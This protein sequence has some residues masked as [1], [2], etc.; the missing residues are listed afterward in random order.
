MFEKFELKVRSI[1]IKFKYLHV[2]LN[3][4][5]C[6]ISSPISFNNSLAQIL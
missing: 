3:V 5:H 2:Y 4:E 1:P 6:Y